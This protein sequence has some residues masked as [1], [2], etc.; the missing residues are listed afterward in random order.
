[1]DASGRGSYI[2]VSGFLQGCFGDFKAFVKVLEGRKIT[3]E[4]Y[5]LF[6]TCVRTQIFAIYR[7]ILI[8]RADL[9]TIYPMKILHL[10][11]TYETHLV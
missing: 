9:I 5:I 8:L 11:P 7:L 1:M 2:R 10:S 6:V 3:N 4:T